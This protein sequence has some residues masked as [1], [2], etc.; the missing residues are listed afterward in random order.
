MQVAPLASGHVGISN[1]A[2]DGLNWQISQ[3]VQ[4]IGNRSHLRINHKS[5][6]Q[7]EAQYCSTAFI[8]MQIESQTFHRFVNSCL[9]D[10]QIHV[11]NA[12]QDSWINMVLKILLKSFQIT[13]C[14]ADLMIWGWTFQV[15][16]ANRQ[17]VWFFRDDNLK[18]SP[19]TSCRFPKTAKLFASSADF[20]FDVYS[21]YT[22]STSEC[23]RSSI[24]TLKA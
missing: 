18:A 20:S 8:D 10:L 19:L 15:S 14:W 9:I 6:L 21:V 17:K 23:K 1:F 11:W 5:A 7:L 13:G 12:T 24:V 2:S 22:S 3:V 4:S 16:G